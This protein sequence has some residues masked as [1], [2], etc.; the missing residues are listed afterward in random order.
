MPKLF[1]IGR[2]LFALALLVFGVQYLIYAF[3]KSWPIPGPPWFPGSHLVAGV[4]GLGLLVAAVSIAARR[5]AQLAAA[6]LGFVFLVRVAVVHLPMLLSNIHNPGPWTSGA[7]MLCIAGGA[8]VLAG[9]LERTPRSRVALEIGR[10]LYGAPLIVFGI[11]HFMYARFVAT[12]VPSWIPGQYFWAIFVGVAFISASAA[13]MSGKFAWL[14][15]MLL[16]IMF[17]SWFLILH[18]PRVVA[19]LHDGNEWTSAFVALAMS[20]C[21][22]VLAG[23]AGRPKGEVRRTK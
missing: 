10:N 23:A 7:E 6:V 13:I 16:G 19:K 2:V 22:L 18:L 8:L 1:D 11:Q 21:A 5:Q 4:A 9:A 20:G 3:G 12:L 15:S 17:A 14:A